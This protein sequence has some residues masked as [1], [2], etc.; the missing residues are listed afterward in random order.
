MFKMKI[1]H[2]MW[3]THNRRKFLWTIPFTFVGFLLG[4]FFFCF[5]RIPKVH[6][7][8][9]CLFCLNCRFWHCKINH[10]MFTSNFLRFE[11][12]TCRMGESHKICCQ[13]ILSVRLRSPWILRCHK[14]K[15]LV[16]RPFFFLLF[17]F[18]N[19]RDRACQGGSSDL[20]CSDLA[21]LQFSDAEDYRR[22]GFSVKPAKLC[23][24]LSFI[25]FGYKGTSLL[26]TRWWWWWGWPWW[27]WRWRGGGRGGD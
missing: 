11:W 9:F 17:A 22:T 27:W 5:S 16:L 2:K 12:C 15:K 3:S 14:K 10:T 4:F 7:C 8:L 13:E 24:F 25:C 6:G 26:N 18:H 21:D 23:N 19:N 1:E 20:D